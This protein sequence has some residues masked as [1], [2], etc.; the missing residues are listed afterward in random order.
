M[1]KQTQSA[2]DEA[3]ELVRQL[4]YHDYLYWEKHSPEIT[5]ADYDQLRERLK[6]L[7]PDHPQLQKLGER[8]RWKD[9]LHPPFKHPA[10]MLSIEKSFEAADIEKWATDCGAF[11]GSS[12]EDGVTACYKIDGSSCSLHYADGKLVRAVTRGDGRTGNDITLNVRRIAD[13]PQ[14]IKTTERFE[15]RGEIFLTLEA[16]ENAISR[17]GLDVDKSNPRNLCAGS[18][19]QNDPREVEKMNLSFMAHTSVGQIPGS[20][21]KSDVS[22]FDALKKL[23]FETPFV[24]HIRTPAEIAETIQEIDLKRDSLPYETDGIVFT[25]NRIKLHDDLGLTGH[26]PRYRI[27]FKFG[28]Q[29]GETTVKGILWST[30]RSGR[31]CPTMEVEPVKLGGAWVSLCTLHNAKLVKERRVTAGDRVVIEREVIPHFVENRGGKRDAEL[32]AK[33]PS[34]AGDLAWDETHTNIFCNNKGGCP[35]QVQDYLEHYTSRSVTNMKG[36]GEKIIH[37][38]VAAGLVKSPADFYTLTAEMI[39][40]KLERQGE[41]SAKNIVASIQSHREQTLETF[42]ASLGIRGLGPTVAQR[43]ANHFGTLEAITHA[44]P[45]KFMEVENTAETMGNAIHRGLAERTTLIADLLKHITLKESA[46]VSGHLSDKS[47]CLTGHVEFDFDSKHYDARPDIEDLI[48]SKGGT[49]KSVSKKLD[50]LVV[51]EDAGSKIEKA[52]KA[53]VKIID[54]AGLIKLLEGKA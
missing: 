6:E 24:R 16:F 5:D 52:E 22:N 47:F 19:I 32:P 29:Q 25:I 54:A 7:A 4:T 37:Q 40:T 33:C 42:L 43:L 18:V 51:G 50:Y 45:E 15:V 17:L 8:A 14:E 3:E 10:P 35:A 21:G 11:K 44:T 31:V 26:H 27:A 2:A 49:I 13:I 41:T 36:V 1:S 48:K 20:N 30:S 28:R 38:L 53:G 34:C 12:E 46:K 39:M 23:G 9:D